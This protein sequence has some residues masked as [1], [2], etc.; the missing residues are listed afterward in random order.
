MY[1]C[2]YVCM[3]VPKTLSVCMYVCM[4]VYIFMY[5]DKPYKILICVLKYKL[6]S[7]LDLLS[8]CMYDM[9]GIYFDI[10]IVDIY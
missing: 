5:I 3:H 1:I 6:Y 10:C 7:I 2:M 4:Y 8:I 9:H